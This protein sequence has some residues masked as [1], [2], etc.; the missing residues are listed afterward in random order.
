VASE[1][2]DLTDAALA[3]G[4]RRQRPPATIDLTATD[5]PGEQAAS[6]AAEHVT[7]PE[8]PVVADAEAAQPPD[9]TPRPDRHSPAASGA[10]PTRSE[11]APR[12]RRR[13]SV[14]AFV[15]AGAAVALLATGLQWQLGVVASRDAGSDELAARIAGLEL[16]LRDL[17]NRPPFAD[18]SAGDLGARMEGIERQLARLEASLAHQDS[19]SGAAPSAA[20]AAPDPALTNRVAAAET[21]VQALTGNVADL[22]ARLDS[23]AT[24]AAS[25]PAAAPAPVP[26]DQGELATLTARVAALES[27]IRALDGR[28][29]ASASAS[30]SA[31]RA[32][33]GRLAASASAS[34]SAIRAL[35]GRLTA[36]ASA[37]VSAADVPGRVALAALELRVAV[38]R[39]VPF[40]AE[41]AA[42][43]PLIRDKDVL[44]ALQPVAAAGVPTAQA[45]SRELADVS[46]A[47]LRAAGPPTR[48][49]GLIERLEANASRLVHIRP[50]EESPGDDPSTVIV[51]AEVKATRG[52]IPGAL[53]EFGTLPAAVKAPAAAWMT[54]AQQRVAAVEAARKLSVGAIAALGKPA[55]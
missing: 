44:D 5:V 45:L 49:G 53:A 23:V 43:E 29:T 32:L 48:G 13:R 8:S 52:D 47:M 42:A 10:A 28:L 12:G 21:A 39:G 31:I 46:P 19:A 24:N 14:L 50:I 55:P 34:E 26:A 3:P 2:Q 40:A 38:E 15:V 25:P 27:A 20:A 9:G 1:E 18:T 17:A 11:P 22:R 54:S 4:G 16:E 7:E 36:S 51:R 30:E 33:D 35:D 6:A 41:L 37:P